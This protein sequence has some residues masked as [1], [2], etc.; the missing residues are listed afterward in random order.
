MKMFF[1]GGI[2]FDADRKKGKIVSAFIIRDGT[3]IISQ[4]FSLGYGTTPEAEYHGLILGLKKLVE[5][6]ISD[7]EIFGD[8]QLIIY[9]IL[10]K[11]SC[12]S[13]NL[14]PLL[15]EAKKL[16]GNNKIS[17]IPRE[18]NGEADAICKGGLRCNI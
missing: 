3:N 17:W 11:Y 18:L 5:L 10:G 1:D 9:Q 14:K 15:S 6:N 16:I 2:K 4:D 8:S 12:D 7:V 13:E